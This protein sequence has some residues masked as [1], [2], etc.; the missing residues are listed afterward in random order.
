[1]EKQTRKPDDVIIVDGGSTDQTHQLLS[2]WKPTFPFQWFEHK[3]NRSVGRNAAIFTAKSSIIAI[4]DAGCAPT[5]E[6][7]DRITKRLI[8]NN[9]DV[10]S[11]Y[12]TP[13][14]QTNFE[15][16]A[17]AYMLVMPDHINPNLFLPATRSMALKKTIWEKAGGFDERLGDNED[18]AFAKS[19]NTLEQR[20]VLK[21][22]YCSMVAA[23]NMD[24]ISY[25][26]LAVCVWRLFAGIIRPKVMFIFLRWGVFIGFGYGSFPLFLFVMFLYTF[27]TWAKNQ[28]YL[29]SFSAIYLLP[30]MQFATDLVVMVGSAQGLAAKIFQKIYAKTNH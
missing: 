17:S 6:W 11:G 2:S 20:S 24:Y 28:K 30:C 10:V 14:A 13:Q 9:C 18:Y 1:M 5:P 7:L 26:S 27:W 15:K 16:G 12:Y 21:R 23:K 29:R 19:F 4:T 8:A 25:A 22:C 3:G